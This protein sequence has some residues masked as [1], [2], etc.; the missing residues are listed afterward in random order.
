MLNTRSA[1]MPLSNAS[2]NPHFGSSK[3]QEVS[4]TIAAPITANV[5]T[6]I[7]KGCFS[8]RDLVSEIQGAT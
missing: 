6:A 5:A 3:A 4:D 2:E 7:V 8:L 1:A